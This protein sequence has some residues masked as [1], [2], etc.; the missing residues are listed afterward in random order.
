MAPL[1]KK[2]VSGEQTKYKLNLEFE[3]T[4]GQIARSNLIASELTL[5][6]EWQLS[7]DLKLDRNTIN[8]WSNVLALQDESAGQY[9]DRIPAVFMHARSNTLHIC[10]SVNNNWNHC[11]NTGYVGTNWFNLR[12]GQREEDAG[13]RYEIYINGD[14]EYSVL[15]SSPEVFS[16]VRVELANQSFQEASKGS[17]RNFQISTN[18]PEPVQPTEPP[19]PVIL[20]GN[21][22][23][24]E[25]EILKI[26]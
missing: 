6:K 11:H 13:Y 19:Q 17:F 1:L 9:G 26:S 3:V 21:I 25:F 18:R 7:V 5:Y 15:N 22:Q 4:Q 23:Y 14:L 12:I 10:N 24:G 20:P 8:N 16:N 2:Y